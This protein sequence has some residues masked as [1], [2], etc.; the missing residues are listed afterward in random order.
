MEPSSD[1]ARLRRAYAEDWYSW[2]DPEVPE[3]L[4][5]TWYLLDRHVAAGHG[6][7]TAL[8]VD[9]T[10]YTYS[11][12]LGAVERVAAGL[13]AIGVARGARLLVVGTDSLEFV[14]LWLACVRTGVVPVVVSDAV[15]A[16]Q[17]AYYLRD[18]EPSALYIDAAQL[19]KLAEAAGEVPAPPDVLF[20]RGDDEAGTGYWRSTRR[21]PFEDV[22]GADRPSVDPV[23]LHAGD[24]AYMLYS[25]STTGPAKGVTHLTHDFLLVPERQGAYWEYGPDDVVHATSKKF[26]THGLWPGVLIPLYWGATAVV[27][28]KPATGAD[29]ARIVEAHRPTKL[30]TVP[31]TVKAILQHV[32]E[33]GAKPD[34][35]SVRMVVTA[36]EQVPTE[37][38]VRFD[39]L[40]GLELMD[41]IGSSEVTYEW[42][43]NRPADHRRG[44]LG[45]P[46]FG[47]ELKLVAEDGNE[48]VE[49]DAEGEAWVRSRTACLFYWRKYDA[50][51]RTFVGEWTRTGDVLAV[52]ADGY[53]RF[54]GRRDDLFKVRGMWV[55]PL[56]VEGTIAAHPDVHEVAVVGTTDA[57]GLTRPKA[58]VVLRGGAAGDA[59]LSAELRARV[60][61]VGG[62]KVPGEIEYIE[63]LPRTPLMKIDRRALREAF[64]VR[65]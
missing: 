59:E 54:V 29:V 19:P 8:V 45:R 4:S 57:D 16:S 52:T 22:I 27:S 63:A 11:E 50:T 42:I 56:E 31:T 25:G 49:P 13:R 5:P 9:D 38:A 32:D 30:I 36:S 14:A 61:A 23:R 21:V 48:V 44:T 41:S 40:F 35:S 17:L 6:S 3:Y 7:K 46:V 39:A 20:V 28:G 18:A 15:K 58:F 43:A 1:L 64:P 55:S 37:I 24:V 51:R 60:R 12:V 2:V 47:Y 10:P 53:F 62:Y 26:F 65:P 34:F 33:T